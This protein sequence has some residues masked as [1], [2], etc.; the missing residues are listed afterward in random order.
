MNICDRCYQT[1]GDIVPSTNTLIFKNND[2]RFHLC[3]SCDDAMK[4][5]IYAVRKEKKRKKN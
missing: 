5:Y 4:E 1:K 2:E 3:S